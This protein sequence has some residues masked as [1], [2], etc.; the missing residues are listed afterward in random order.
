[1]RSPLDSKC[2]TD[3]CCRQSG[4]RTA[5]MTRLCSG[6]GIVLMAQFNALRKPSAGPE[7]A[8]KLEC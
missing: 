4:V 8:H 2:A 6:R 3:Y 1:M 7:F 5:I